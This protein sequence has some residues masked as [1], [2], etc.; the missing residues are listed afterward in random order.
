MELEKSNL[1]LNILKSAV[2][3]KKL[4]HAYI[5]YGVDEF[6]KKEVCKSFAKLILCET[7]KEDCK[8]CSSC[9]KFLNGNHPDFFEI[10]TEEELKQSF[11]VETVRELI[12]QCF[13]KP[14]ESL[15]KIFLLKDVDNLNLNASNALLKILEQPPKNVIFM[16]T[17]TNKNNVL[18][19]IFS[20]CVSFFIPPVNFKECLNFLN[21][22]NFKLAEEE[23]MKIANLSGGNLGLL[24]F[25]KTEEGQDVLKFSENL[26][27]AFLKEDELNF[28]G[29]LQRNEKNLEL[30]LKILNC[31]LLRLSNLFEGKCEFKENE[32]EK[33]YYVFNFLDSAIF[34]L[35]KN[36]NVSI[37]LS[38]LC[39]EIFKT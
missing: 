29:I 13:V 4:A 21:S 22:L 14:N 1:V 18:G 17:A 24:K 16:L 20:R 12:K 38:G 26:L 23:L 27:D 9:R 11:T 10:G 25:F 30:I 15:F 5:F 37:A 2:K 3:Q 39:C 8:I 34:N 35:K 31:F 36:C 33:F 6:L 32:I 28:C 7:K 19:T